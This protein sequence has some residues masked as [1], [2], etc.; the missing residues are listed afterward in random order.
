MRHAQ[1]LLSRTL[2]T[3]DS[4][5]RFSMAEWDLLVRQARAAGLL[6]R[7]AALFRQRAC[8]SAVPPTIRW[9]FE[10]AEALSSKQQTAVRWELEQLRRALA[11]LKGSPIV[12]K[13]AAYVGAALP[14]RAGRLFNDI[15]VLV[16]RD[17]LG[18][19]ESLLMLSG[20]HATDLSEYDKRYYRRWM[21]EIP[22]LQHVERESIIDLHHAIL[23]DTARYRP[24]TSKL[25]S[26][27]V[28]LE[29]FPGVYVLA[30]EDRILHSATH[31]F[32]DGELPHGL[33]DL[34][35][36]DLLLREAAVQAGFWLRLTTRAEELDLVRPLFYALRY[37]RYFLDTPVPA[38]VDARLRAG[39]PNR[40][41]TRLM[42]AIFTRA[43][44]PMHASYEDV[45]T[46]AA[47]MAAYVRAHWLRMPPHLLVPHLF[48]KAF[49]SPFAAPRAPRP[50]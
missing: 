39:A 3:S 13:G 14:A 5:S 49:I 4:L 15:D 30:V 28:P 7:L 43:L 27:A 42:D 38:E 26:R 25:R 8:E 11:D 36:L 2:R 45:L 9:H 33:R 24:D 18:E 17:Q 19:A 1:D 23:P 44:A 41:L 21:H 16:P 29:D 48:H 47:R 12:L 46:P 10:A 35:D 31:L 22:P 6:A 40:W 50:A 34:S 20:W 32:H 37:A